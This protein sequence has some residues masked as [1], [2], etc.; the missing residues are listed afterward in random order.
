MSTEYQLL[1]ANKNYS[2]WSFRP[3]LLLKKLDIPFDETLVM[4]K[5]EDFS[6]QVSQFSPAG[7]V[8]V[9]VDGDVAVWDSHAIMEYVAEAYPEAWP[10]DRE[11]R[12]LARSVSAEMHSGFMGLRNQLPMNCRAE[13]RQVA[14]DESCQKDIERIQAIWTEC[15]LRYGHTGPWLFGRFT[16]ADAMFAPVVFRFYSYGVN[17][18]GEAENYMQTMMSDPAVLE[19]RAAALKEDAVIMGYEAGLTA[20]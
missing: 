9:L 8:P 16:I 6:Q 20:Q 1:I 17:C 14:F 11:A 4:L 2:S 15:R 7:K 10:K 3:W 19:W 12:A 18:H 13:G 5:S